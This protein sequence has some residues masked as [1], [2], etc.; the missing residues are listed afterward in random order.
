MNVAIFGPRYSPNYDGVG[1]HAAWIADALI[2]AGH[3]VVVVTESL[4]ARPRC[5]VVRIGRWDL[6][7]LG[8]IA[9]ALRGRR[10]DVALFEYT[11]FNFGSRTF[12]PHALAIAL[13]LRGTRV[14]T[15]LHEA[16]YRPRGT[17]PMPPLKALA[18]GVRDAVMTAASHAVF[19]ASPERADAIVAAVPFFRSRVHVIPIGANV[20]PAPREIWTPPPGP[21]YRLVTFGVVAARRR[22]DLIVE[23]I[24]RAAQR[25]IRIELT[26]LGRIYDRAYAERCETRARDLAVADRV[27]FT[28]ELPPAEV[29]RTMSDAH[30]AVH[31][32]YEGAISSSGSLLAVLAHGIPLLAVRTPRDERIFESLAVF[33]SEDPD[34]MLDDA[35]ALIASSDGGAALG[36]RARARYESDFAWRSIAERSIAG[37]IRTDA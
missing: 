16:F 34:A 7:A 21:P 17:N 30:L 28:R 4:A 3:D 29:T 25:G 24:A 6:R 2:D 33:T 37:C 36:R 23:M 22:I 12:T 14:A 5:E 19:A 8:T 15:F 11:P 26:V 32:L 13:R 1:D 9:A 27:R 18:L 20:E 31:A 10:I 35:L